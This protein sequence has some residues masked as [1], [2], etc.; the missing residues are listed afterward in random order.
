MMLV[1]VVMHRFHS[2]C[3]RISIDMAHLL[4]FSGGAKGDKKISLQGV[5][6]D[7]GFECLPPKDI[8]SEKNP[9]PFHVSPCA[10]GHL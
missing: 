4:S 5:T 8:K 2:R 7:A 1:M 10:Y 9:Q 3:F 6:E